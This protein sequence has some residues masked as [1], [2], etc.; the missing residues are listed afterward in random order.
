MKQPVYSAAGSKTPRQGGPPSLIRVR[1]ERVKTVASLLLC[2]LC[3]ATT[4]QDITQYRHNTQHRNNKT[5][6]TKEMRP[7]RHH[8]HHY[9]S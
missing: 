5:N 1:G 8:F 6:N 3:D 9:S 2:W 7:H 4:V